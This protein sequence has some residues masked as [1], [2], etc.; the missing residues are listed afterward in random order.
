[1]KSGDCIAWM[2]AC[3][4]DLTSGERCDPQDLTADKNRRRLFL[5]KGAFGT[6]YEGKKTSLDGR[7]TTRVAVKIID[8]ASLQIGTDISNTQRSPAPGKRA[9]GS[10]CAQ[11]SLSYEHYQA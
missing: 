7:K 1:M 6:V 9:N 5:G 11:G 3:A 2:D 4:I 10:A 8:T